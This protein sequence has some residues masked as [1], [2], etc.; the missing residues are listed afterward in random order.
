[1]VVRMNFLYVFFVF[2]EDYKP[3]RTM[4]LFLSV[5]LSFFLVMNVYSQNLFFMMI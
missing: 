1:M 4:K 3:K 5:T 2:K